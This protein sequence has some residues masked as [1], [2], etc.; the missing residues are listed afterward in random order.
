MRKL[1]LLFAFLCAVPV[2]A[3]NPTLVQG[4]TVVHAGAA[5]T[6]SFQSLNGL[7]T[8]GNSALVFS[9][10]STTA[11]LTIADVNTGGTPQTWTNIINNVAVPAGGV[12][13]AWIAYTTNVT[14]T[15][16]TMTVTANTA[17]TDFYAGAAE[18]NNL[19]SSGFDKGPASAAGLTSG[20]VTPSNNIELVLGV[21]VGG[22]GGANN[23]AGTGYTLISS[24]D[25]GGRNPGWESK[26][27]T[28]CGAQTASFTSS[29]GTTQTNILTFKGTASSTCAAGNPSGTVGGSGTSGGNGTIGK[30]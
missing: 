16:D 10:C 29:S 21:I 4:G 15:L 2:M 8:T 9:Y 20:S 7:F 5:T 30:K 19:T 23:V 26:V 28:T 24:N 18:A 1:L 12:W 3:Q 17:C 13:S 22:D 11:T 27:V 6:V 25:T 14:P